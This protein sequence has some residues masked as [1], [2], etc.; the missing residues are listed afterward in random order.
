MIQESIAPVGSAETHMSLSS[1]AAQ[2]LSL[3][4]GLKHAH[5]LEQEAHQLM[6]KAQSDVVASRKALRQSRKIL[7]HA[8]GE[9]R[10]A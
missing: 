4:E 8:E 7:R 6:A 9:K 1:Q 10:G 3:S 2:S 5:E